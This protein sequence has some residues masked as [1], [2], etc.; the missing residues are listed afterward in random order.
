MV[1]WDKW[2]R[3]S[4][5]TKWINNIDKIQTILIT[6]I[7]STITTNTTTTINSKGEIH[8]NTNKLI[9]ISQQEHNQINSLLVECSLILKISIIKI[10]IL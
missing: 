2:I 10:K 1:K 4:K 3:C 9:I 6:I 5:W 8:S 7:N